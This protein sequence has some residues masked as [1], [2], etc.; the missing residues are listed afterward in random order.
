[1]KQLCQPALPIISTEPT[2][3][4][5]RV[6]LVL[7]YI[8]F[9]AYKMLQ[10]YMFAPTTRRDTLRDMKHKVAMWPFISERRGKTTSLGLD[11]RG[12]NYKARCLL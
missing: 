7:L 9:P 11:Q 6:K 1:M 8:A 12:N 4:G 3:K 2:V 10:N 5:K